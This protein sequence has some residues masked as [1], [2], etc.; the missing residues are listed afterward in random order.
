M[1]FRVGQKVVCVDAY[2]PRL[3]R[4]LRWIFRW[5][6]PLVHGEV[7]IVQRATVILREEAVELVE[8]KNTPLTDGCFAAR[9]FRPAVDRKTSIEV[10]KKM[11]NPQGA[12]A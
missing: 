6:W 10:F 4:I 5:G 1:T 3:A 9:R 12:D 11:L 2:I 8:V 7:Y